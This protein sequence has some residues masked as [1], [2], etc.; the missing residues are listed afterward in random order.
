MFP[1][2][3]NSALM[4]IEKD[5]VARSIAKQEARIAKRATREADTRRREREP[6]GWFRVVRRA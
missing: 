3:L 1:T 4:Q 5:A 6:R 2:L